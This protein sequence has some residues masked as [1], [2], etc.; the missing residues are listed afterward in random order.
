MNLWLF[1]L[2]VRTHSQP[3]V[4][5]RQ[6]VLADLQIKIRRLFQVF[7]PVFRQSPCSQHIEMSRFPAFLILNYNF[8]GGCPVL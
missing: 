1:P 5:R 8:H 7:H 4:R 3:P 2:A 6:L